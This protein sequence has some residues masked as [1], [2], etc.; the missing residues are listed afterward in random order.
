MS[1]Q[2]II[3]S[4]TSQTAERPQNSFFKFA[5]VSFDNKSFLKVKHLVEFRVG[6]LEFD[7]VRWQRVTSKESR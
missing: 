7:V 2:S 5:S 4:P 6:N 3:Y 1:M